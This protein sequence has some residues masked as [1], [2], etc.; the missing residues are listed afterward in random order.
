MNMKKKKKNKQENRETE[1]EKERDDFLFSNFDLILVSGN[2]LC[3]IEAN[4]FLW[5]NFS[6]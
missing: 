2:E 3:P 1:R 5:D 4:I 6:S